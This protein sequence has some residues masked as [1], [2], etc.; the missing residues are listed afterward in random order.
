MKFIH[1]GCWNNGKCSAKNDLTNGLTK[2]TTLLNKTVSESDFDFITIVGDNYYP[3]KKIIDDKKFKNFVFED[4]KSGFDCLPSNI[5]KF[6]IFGNHYI[7]DIVIDDKEEKMCHSLLLQ[8]QIASEND[9]YILFD[10]VINLKDD[11]NLIIMI[12]TTLYSLE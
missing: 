2:M 9:K 10:N 5:N 3:G 1:F 8:K 12:D 6:V 11:N 7:E 4:F